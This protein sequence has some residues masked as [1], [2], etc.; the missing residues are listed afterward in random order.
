MPGP[1]NPFCV[2]GNKTS[3]IAFSMPVGKTIPGSF[4]IISNAECMKAMITV[5]KACAEPKLFVKYFEESLDD[6]LG[7]KAW[8]EWSS[9]PN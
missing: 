3:S 6:I 8:R 1:K 9:G 5:D 2:A 4:G 7:S